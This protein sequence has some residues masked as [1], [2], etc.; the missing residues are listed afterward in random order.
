MNFSDNHPTYNSAY[1]YVTK[2]D[3]ETLH[4]PCN[5]DLTDVPP[6]TESAVTTK[7]RKSKAKK[8]R[9]RSKKRGSD[10]LRTFD[11]CQLV[12]AKSISSRL[13]LVSSAATQVR[14]GKTALAEF[15][16]NRG[17]KAV[18]EAIQ[19]AKEFAEAETRL[20]RSKKSALNC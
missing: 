13:E 11:V 5:P 14:E 8:Q 3:N 15:I 2:E 20:S 19:L 6:Q 12:Q 9:R 17:S 16:A 18:D 10:H 1:R 4:S 7:K